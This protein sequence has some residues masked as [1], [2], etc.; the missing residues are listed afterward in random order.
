MVV[1]RDKTLFLLYKFS[2][3]FNM[4]ISKPY[5][6]VPS[7]KNSAKSLINPFDFIASLKVIFGS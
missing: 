2:F 7:G 4:I 5:T 3:L 1:N 6:D